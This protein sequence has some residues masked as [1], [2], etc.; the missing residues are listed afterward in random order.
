MARFTARILM[1]AAPYRN[2]TR[3]GGVYRE[4][5]GNGYLGRQALRS[6]VRTMDVDR[7]VREL[8]RSLESEGRVV[9]V[10]GDGDY[11]MVSAD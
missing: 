1:E 4:S 2:M 11:L 9:R 7:L 3:N 10:T 8:T 6:P 5:R